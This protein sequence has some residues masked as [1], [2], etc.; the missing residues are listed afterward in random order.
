LLHAAHENTTTDRRTLIT[1]WYQPDF[2]NLPE[3]IQA[4][5]VAKTQ[6]IPGEWPESAKN[7]LESLLPKYTGSAAPYDRSLYRKRVK[8]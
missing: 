7:L 8:V 3:R 1:L 2:A 6:K 4:Q 5:M